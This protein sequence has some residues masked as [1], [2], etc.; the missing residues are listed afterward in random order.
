MATP[1]YLICLDCETPCY[2]F[3]WHRDTLQEILCAICGNEDPDRFVTADDYDAMEGD[4][5]RR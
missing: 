4:E 1:D 5:V 3:E 2:D